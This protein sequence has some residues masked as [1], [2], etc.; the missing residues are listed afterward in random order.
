MTLFPILFIPHLF[1]VLS[2]PFF[3]VPCILLALLA[4]LLFID[5][6]YSVPVLVVVTL[7]VTLFFAFLFT[8]VL[9][10]RPACLVRWDVLSLL[11]V[12]KLLKCSL[13]KSCELQNS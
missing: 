9:S 6:F 13:E 8:L 10:L 12:V 3:I 1:A 5:I 11:W 7:L 4:I 2:L